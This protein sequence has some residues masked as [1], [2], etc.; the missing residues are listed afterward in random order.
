[1]IINKIET[2]NMDNNS[3]SL[4]KSFV[5]IDNDLRTRQLENMLELE[6]HYVLR[7]DYFTS[8]VTAWHRHKLLTW[9]LEVCE[10]EGGELTETAFGVAVNMFD[11]FMSRESRR[12]D[13]QHLQLLGCVCLFIAA[14]VT[15]GRALSAEKLV[16]YAD[17]S[18]GVVDILEWESL[19]LST[20][21]WDVACVQANDFIDLFVDPLE[22]DSSVVRRTRVYTALCLTEFKFAFYPA[23]M[24]AAACLLVSRPSSRVSLATELGHDLECLLGLTE[25][26]TGLVNSVIQP[27]ISS[28]L[29]ELDNAPSSPSSASSSDSSSTQSSPSQPIEFTSCLTQ[30]TTITT[31]TTNINVE[32]EDD[33]DLLLNDLPLTSLDDNHFTLS[34]PIVIEKK[35]TNNR[36]KSNSRGKTQHHRNERLPN[37]QY[38]S[39]YILTPPQP[40]CLPM[41]TF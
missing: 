3:N 5:V 31:T 21:Q 36:K 39:Y 22:L 28:E 18:I 1:M 7:H 6:E 14:K 24:L 10:E 27:P 38:C 16:D 11:R 29:S 8:R 12:I 9:L 40:S 32:F 25:L 26:V 33:Y 23:S 2:K 37:Q 13:V 17:N 41:P 4:L 20:L 35:T 30:T 19:V 34:S 15:A